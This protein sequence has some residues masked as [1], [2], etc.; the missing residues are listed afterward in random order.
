MQEFRT[1]MGP[2]GRVLIPAQCRRQMHLTPGEEVI[3]QLDN[4]QLCLV[5]LKFSLNTAQ[6]LVRQHAKRR[7]LTTEL[8]K[9]RQEDFKRE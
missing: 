1:K 6:K 4:E 2:D 9:M 5:T 7:K 3:L 8:K